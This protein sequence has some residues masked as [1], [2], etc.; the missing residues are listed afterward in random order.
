MGN[1]ECKMDSDSDHSDFDLSK[2][3]KKKGTELQKKLKGTE[4]EAPEA[5]TALNVGPVVAG[6][7]LLVLG[8]GAWSLLSSPSNSNDPE[9]SKKKK[10]GTEHESSAVGSGLKVGAAV[11]LTT[12]QA[13]DAFNT[14]SSLLPEITQAQAVGAMNRFNHAGVQQG[15][16][17]GILLNLLYSILIK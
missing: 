13:V 12:F 10:K 5:I 17:C 8:L 11:A 15:G 4:D 3:L 9:Q 16:Y 6:A 2:K 7:A 1:R 14:V